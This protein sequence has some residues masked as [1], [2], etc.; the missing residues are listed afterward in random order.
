V[1]KTS[2]LSA[3][4]SFRRTQHHLPAMMKSSR[5]RY[6]DVTGFGRH[7]PEADIPDPKAIRHRRNL[8]PGT[9]TQDIVDCIHKR[10]S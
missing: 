7:H 3:S 8:L 9:S 10:V 4:P 5:T 2:T 6:A 1:Q